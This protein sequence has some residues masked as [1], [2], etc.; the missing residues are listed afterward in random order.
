MESRADSV[1]VNG[2]DSLLL[3]VGPYTGKNVGIRTPN[4]LL[5]RKLKEQADEDAKVEAWL[6]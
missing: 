4:S 3:D 2:R 5:L 6:S 1:V